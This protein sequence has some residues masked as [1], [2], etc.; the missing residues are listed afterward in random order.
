MAKLV[1]DRHGVLEAQLDDVHGLAAKAAGFR[2]AS[3][4]AARANVRVATILLTCASL[5]G[6]AAP[7]DPPQPSRAAS[8]APDAGEVASGYRSLQLMT[9]EPVFVEPALALLC[10][11]VTPAEIQKARDAAG[12]HALATVRIFMNDLAAATFGTP[13]VQYPVGS[14]V[15]KEKG[16]TRLPAP[17]GVVHDGVGGM[18]KRA[19]GYDP[20]NGDWEY[21]YFEDVAK[22]ERGRI[23]ACIGCH[24]RAAESD[25]VFGNWSRATR[26]R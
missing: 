25:F 3:D 6:C 8:N 1:A 16:N 10:R 11:G 23:A 14:I 19:P 21:F 5:A 4:S 13:D 22:I 20:E 17:D 2:A 12:P 7:V 15:V 18:I 24:R 26:S 9:K